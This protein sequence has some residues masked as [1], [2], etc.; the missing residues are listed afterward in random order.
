MF[1]SIAV[2]ILS[3]QVL[4]AIIFASDEHFRLVGVGQRGFTGNTAVGNKEESRTIPK[5]L[6][7]SFG[8]EAKLKVIPVLN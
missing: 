4:A 2:A 1:I 7:C 8:I 3:T 5:T 6:L